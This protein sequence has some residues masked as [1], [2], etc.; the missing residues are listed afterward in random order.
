MFLKS[1]E[2]QRKRSM[3]ILKDKEIVL[4]NRK[5]YDKTIV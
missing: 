4:Q 2:K 1:S 3:R 5:N